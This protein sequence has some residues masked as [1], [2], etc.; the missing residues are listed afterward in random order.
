MAS[1]YD[2]L[3]DDEDAEED[4]QLT[5]FSQKY[6]E[7]STEEEDELVINTQKYDTL[8]T[9]CTEG[10]PMCGDTPQCALSLATS[11][12][13]L[14]NLDDN[15]CSKRLNNN[16]PIDAI[17]DDNRMTKKPVPPR[18]PAHLSNLIKS[19][20]RYQRAKT[21]KFGQDDIIE[22]PLMFSRSS[23]VE[24]LS[25]DVD[26]KINIPDHDAGSVIS[27][28]S[29]LTSRVGSPS[30]LPD[31]PCQTM[32]STAKHD[33]EDSTSSSDDEEEGDD[34]ILE[35]CIAMG[36]QGKHDDDTTSS[37]EEEGEGDDKILEQ[38]IA[39]GMQSKRTSL[40][41]KS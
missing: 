26:I 29:R 19:D 24:S 41:V 31:S 7:V 39:M 18:K 34:K 30:N 20:I 16:E 9:Y 28:F 8:K 10:T 36:M 15:F 3:L 6:S 13:D 37:S 22:T 5:D 25:S 2:H 4:D 11:F 32:P 40:Q 14:S 21:V 23:S 38:C 35:Q 1:T 12:N 33:E 17:V 27:E